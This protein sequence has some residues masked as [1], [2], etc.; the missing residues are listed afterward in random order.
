MIR[1][2]LIS[3][4]RGVPTERRFWCGSLTVLSG[5]NGLGKTTFF[6]AV[7]W[8]LFG[9]AWRLGQDEGSVKNL[10]VT[11]EPTVEVSLDLNG[12]PVRV[13]RTST[14]AS[15]D[16]EPI[17]DRGLVERFIRDPDVF[18]PYAR[19]LDA[20]VRQLV[21]LP[22]ADLRALVTA[23]S[24]ETVAAIFQALVG[25]P[26]A[27]LLQS[28]LKRAIARIADRRGDVEAAQRE[29]EAQRAELQSKIALM[30]VQP[31]G[32]GEH[33]EA[34]AQELLGAAGDM[35][36]TDVLL[37]RIAGELIAVQGEVR[38]VRES[39]S[40][41]LRNK[42]RRASL[43]AILELRRR[44]LVKAERDVEE[45]TVEV[46]G[47]DERVGSVVKEMRDLEEE[48][49][50]LVKQLEHVEMA[51]AAV[52][53]SERLKDEASISGARS[54]ECEVRAVDFEKRRNAKRDEHADNQ[55][56][57]VALQIEE[58]RLREDIEAVKQRTERLR[59]KGEATAE[60]ARI[61]GEL[62][63]IRE[64]RESLDRETRDA[65][66]LMERLANICENVEGYDELD[67]NLRRVAEAIAADAEFGHRCPLCGADYENGKAL[68]EHI[69]RA[70][71]A[72][73]S[74]QS[75]KERASQEL[76]SLKE[77][78]QR[79]NQKLSAL[80]ARVEMLDAR[81]RALLARIAEIGDEV[82]TEGQLAA[83]LE[84]A[85]AARVALEAARAQGRKLQLEIQEL[86]GE[87]DR[88]Q[89]GA[90]QG[91]EAA[92]A[93]DKRRQDLLEASS[94]DG[95]E[96]AVLKAR[97]SVAVIEERLRMLDGA[98]AGEQ[99]QNRRA[100]EL[101]EG[102]LRARAGVGGEIETAAEEDQELENDARGLASSL[103]AAYEGDAVP[104]IEAA[105]RRVSE[106]EAR[107]RRL[108]NL[109]RV[110]RKRKAAEDAAGYRNALGGVLKTKDSLDRRLAEFDRAAER[111]LGVEG[112]VRARA[113]IEG[114]GAI[115]RFRSSIQEC[116]DALYPHM[117]LNRL[118]LAA[119]EGAFALTD[120]RLDSS[121]RPELYTSTGQLNVL[122]L[123]LFLGISGV[124][125]VTS[126]D[127]ILLD[128]PVQNLDDVHF[129][130]L[131]TLLKRIA[132]TSQVIIST[133]DRN[134]GELIHRQ[135]ESS[136]CRGPQD[137]SH[138]RW[139]G[140]SATGGP[141]IQEVALRTSAVA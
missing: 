97:S 33:V 88:S 127:F 65:R 44:E 128:E 141:D 95:S 45:A 94:V 2:L 30:A 123:A 140:F 132:L 59:E 37:G 74:R 77:Q 86:D 87:I 112:A 10:Y 98:L 138:Y 15:I 1:E 117:H 85:D 91:R 16:G 62:T 108:E 29:C 78:Q 72:R 137:F 17:S 63:D 11:G 32:E 102:V 48:R 139:R 39:L 60:V 54:I 100:R 52:A 105:R 24:K 106:G 73:T 90:V 121:V 124:Q 107:E 109:D 79:R 56:L 47:S 130:A 115:E 96:E 67:A 119:A 55:R 34:D 111:L 9:A 69:S 46:A 113:A 104:V 99:R 81:R 80:P 49:Q 4:F 25:V 70:A 14:G 42:E 26:H 83:A 82:P 22:Q 101:L 126:L 6:D 122:A 136:W 20:R 93:A 50:R 103:G 7:D 8:C 118:V 53:E 3:G 125:A 57:V 27:K 41:L 120:D 116:L 58:Q 64:V 23:D 71:E 68:R 18:G 21:Y 28:G 133:S 31:D 134:I 5:P 12:V 38:H 84:R 43:A 40:A 75:A 135:A 36:S 131:L 114:S 66:E 13:R 19:N 76:T 51:R 89:K 35:V 129:L 61:E 110:A 92:A